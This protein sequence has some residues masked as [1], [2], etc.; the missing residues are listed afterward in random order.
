MR[1]R[2]RRLAAPGFRYETC[3][4]MDATTEFVRRVIGAGGP[5]LTVSTACS[6]S[7]KVFCVAERYL[8]A[9]LID[10]AVV[11]GADTLCLTTL[12]GFN[13]LQLVS[14]EACRPYDAAR[15]G[16]SIGEAAGFALIEATSE[17]P[18]Q[19]KRLWR[20]QRR[21]PHV[22]A[23]PEGD[24]ARRAMEQALASAGLAPMRSTT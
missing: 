9:G 5:A 13:S 24:A 12:Y 20:D 4:N 11:G 1:S 8:R 18:C 2:C 22:D 15:K 17:A 21:A 6:S 19:L 3:H 23:H 10:A 14:P 16:L 7:A